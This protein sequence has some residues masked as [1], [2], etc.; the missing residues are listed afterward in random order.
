VTTKLH[1]AGT[2]DFHVIEGLLTGGNVSD[3][4]V[5]DE[6]TAE[7]FG[8]YVVED[9]GYDSDVHR[10]RLRSNNN[11]PVIPGRKNRKVKIEYDKAIYRLRRNIE[12]F[13]GKLKENKRLSM[14]FEKLDNTFLGFIALAAIK[15][16]IRPYL[17]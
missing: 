8:C 4:T 14:R 7:V 5:A 15:I 16:W 3:I 2:P 11:V 1:L 6:L 17:C 10:D 12:I 13:F 9:M